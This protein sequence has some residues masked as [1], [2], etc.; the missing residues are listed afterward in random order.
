MRPPRA[1]RSSARFALHPLAQLRERVAQPAAHGVDGHARGVRRLFHRV[2]EQRVKREHLGLDLGQLAQQLAQRFAPP[3]RLNELRGRAIVAREV[4]EVARRCA[5]RVAHAVARLAPRVHRRLHRDAAGEMQRRAL[6]AKPDE[7][8]VHRDHRLLQ[9]VFDLGVRAAEHA[10]HDAQ[11]RRADRDQQRPLR[12]AI[13]RARRRSQRS[14]RVVRPPR[15]PLPALRIAGL[16][17]LRR[18]QEPQHLPNLVPRA[19][20]SDH[21]ARPQ[22]LRAKP[23]RHPYIAGA[24]AL[25]PGRQPKDANSSLRLAEARW[26]FRTMSRQ[27]PGKIRHLS[28]TILDA[29]ACHW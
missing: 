5:R 28:V 25:R 21:A 10:A 22:G 11:Q 18:S 29:N 20:I 15:R 13:A 17:V 24:R 4:G 9:R 12:F 1:R 7:R 8:E 23:T 6:A 3:R 26:W 19:R 16:N 2:A 14:Q 27:Y